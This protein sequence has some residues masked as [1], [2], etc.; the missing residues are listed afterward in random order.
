LGLHL[1][2]LIGDIQVEELEYTGIKGPIF[3]VTC[4]LRELEYA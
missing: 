4:T 3:L 2:A 1:R